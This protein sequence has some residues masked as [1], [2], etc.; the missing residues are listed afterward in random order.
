M[1]F[2]DVFP[3]RSCRMIAAGNVSSF[4]HAWKKVMLDRMSQ[5]RDVK[6]IIKACLGAKV[7]K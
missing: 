4:F 1:H 5:I 3:A 2:P 7:P 6:W